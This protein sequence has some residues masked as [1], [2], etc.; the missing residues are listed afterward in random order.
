[1]ARRNAGAL[2]RSQENESRGKYGALYEVFEW[3]LNSRSIYWFLY[4]VHNIYYFQLSNKRTRV[5][6]E[7]FFVWE[8][9]CREGRMALLKLLTCNGVKNQ[10]LYQFC[11]LWKLHHNPFCRYHYGD[12]TTSNNAYALWCSMWYDCLKWC[13]YI[14]IVRCLPAKS[15]ACLA[16]HNE[17]TPSYQP[18]DSLIV[19][20]GNAP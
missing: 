7:V 20:Q 19:A 14:N 4:S 17:Q 3:L 13:G 5:F 6:R 18:V 12:V 9:C 15:C 10:P 2:T 1:M 16:Y 11:I 8:L